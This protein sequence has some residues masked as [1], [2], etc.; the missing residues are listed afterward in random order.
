VSAARKP[1]AAA[2]LFDGYVLEN[3]KRRRATRAELREA[4]RLWWKH[5]DIRTGRASAP[6]SRRFRW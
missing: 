4:H 6:A 1:K 2:A 5:A 3:G